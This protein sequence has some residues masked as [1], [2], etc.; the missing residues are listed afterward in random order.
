MKK[1]NYYPADLEEL[2][3]EG[4]NV[5]NDLRKINFAI[6]NFARNN[7]TEYYWIHRRFKNR[8]EKEDSFYP[9]D[10]LKK[11]G[12]KE[13]TILSICLTFRYFATAI[14]VH[15]L[16]VTKDKSSASSISK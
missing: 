6:E 9:D 5:E 11:V 13:T 4:L 1:D 3:L 14:K 8:P 10:A 12:Y 16:F 7:M 2:F 15:C